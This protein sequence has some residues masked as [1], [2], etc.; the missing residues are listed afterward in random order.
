M[1]WMRGDSREDIGEPGLRID[2]VHFGGDDEA[3]HGRRA[4]AAAIRTAEQPGF[5]AKGNSAQP[6]FCGVVREANAPVFEEERKGRPTLEH[7]LHR[8][9]EIMPTRE[10]GDL[11]AHIVFQR[12]N[13]RP[14]HRLA[15]GKTFF[16]ALAV[17]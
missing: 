5:P 10:L 11:I 17:D 14:A 12:V 4:L 2:A 3:I 13:E 16:G 7:I 1:R 6:T 15:N 9:G 8:L